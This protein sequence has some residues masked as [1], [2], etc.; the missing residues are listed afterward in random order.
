MT[1]EPISSAT[2]AVPPPPGVFD[3]I[4]DTFELLRRHPRATMLPFAAIS[5][6]VG[7]AAAMASAVLFLTRFDDEPYVRSVF[8]GDIARGP[9]FALVI[10]L[11]ISSLFAVV[12]HA[13][14][15][16]AVASA[17][18]GEPLSLSRALD[19]AFTRMGGL[20]LLSLILVAGAG[21]LAFTLVGL[22]VLPYLLLRFGLAFQ[23]FMLEESAPLQALLSSW[24]LMSGHMLRLLGL[25]LIIGFGVGVYVAII[26][27]SPL[28]EDAPRNAR[29][30][31]DAVLDSLRAVLVVPAAVFYQAALTLY[32]LKVRARY[33]AR[34]R[35]V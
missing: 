11:V 29:I 15:I 16:V 22:L 2:P 25:V 10:I 8:D 33:D 18:R 26:S 1:T 6:P 14:S 30:A 7:I 19:P 28:G 9:L 12:G 5:I 24:R 27:V 34:L 3:T 4:S 21:A 32:Y 35:D 20:V 31:T 17:A 13:A 23:T